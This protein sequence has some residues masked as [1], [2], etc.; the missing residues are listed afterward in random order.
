M[1]AVVERMMAK[2][3]EDRYQTADEVCRALEPFA[4]RRP[5]EFDFDAVLRSRSKAARRRI[6]ATERSRG[7][8]SHTVLV[9]SSQTKLNPPAGANE[10]PGDGPDSDTLLT[11]EADRAAGGSARLE[12]DPEL[13]ELIDAWGNL[14]DY[15]KRTIVQ[16]A[17]AMHVRKNGD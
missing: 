8:S 3:P 6:A 7:L 11:S 17:K 5:V 15:V 12:M 1:V 9:S 10:L 16:M 2:N 4:E 14:P 13:A